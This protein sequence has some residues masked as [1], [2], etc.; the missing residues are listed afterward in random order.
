MEAQV[1]E[2]FLRRSPHRHKLEYLTLLYDGGS[3]PY[4]HVAALE[5]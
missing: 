3:K 1:A 4:Y 2:F 5:L